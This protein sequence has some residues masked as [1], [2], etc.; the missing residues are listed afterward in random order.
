M[1]YKC[2]QPKKKTAPVAHSPSRSENVHYVLCPR[3]KEMKAT[4]SC[5]NCKKAMCAKHVKYICKL[6][7]NLTT[8]NNN[9]YKY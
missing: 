2:T 3:N 1:D 6:S 7:L 4:A 8:G 9:C 5:S